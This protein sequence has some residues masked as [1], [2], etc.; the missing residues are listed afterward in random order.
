MKDN[1]LIPWRKIIA[2]SVLTLLLIFILGFIDA[3]L[4]SYFVITMKTAHILMFAV[5]FI[6]E[7]F[8][9][10]IVKAKD[11]NIIYTILSA[12]IS[13][14]MLLTLGMFMKY[15]FN[16]KYTLYIFLTLC[17]AAVLNSITKAIIK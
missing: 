7:F 1:M 8:S 10:F 6:A 9:L 5:V 14:L 2:S 4:C 16:C 15:D 3:L 17:I 12:V 13:F 11:R